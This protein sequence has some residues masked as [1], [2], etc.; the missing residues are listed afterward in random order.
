[1]DLVDDAVVAAALAICEVVSKSPLDIT[2]AKVK[3]ELTATDFMGTSGRVVFDEKTQTRVATSMPYTVRYFNTTSPGELFTTTD[4]FRYWDGSFHEAP[5]AP[6]LDLPANFSWKYDP[7]PVIV[8]K[9]ETEPVNPIIIVIA[10]VAGILGIALASYAVWIS[11]SQ[12]AKLLSRVA[13]IRTRKSLQEGPITANLKLMEYI[14]NFFRGYTF[15]LSILMT[16]YDKMKASR[17]KNV[18][19][20][21][22]F[23]DDSTGKMSKF[24]ELTLLAEAVEYDLDATDN[25]LGTGASATVCKGLL[26]GQTPVAVKVVGLEGTESYIHILCYNRRRKCDTHRET[27]FARMPFSMHSSTRAWDS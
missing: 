4:I 25:I 3:D 16:G 19:K 23:L 24:R 22:R 11:T 1:M 7:P 9:T 8:T 20:L 15:L 5:G 2:T 13:S 17:D 12:N 6:K 21:R 26:H 14:R 10:A 18:A 27:S